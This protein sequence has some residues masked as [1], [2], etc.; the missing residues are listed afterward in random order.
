M[1]LQVIQAHSPLLSTQEK[2]TEEVMI[3]SEE[4]PKADSVTGNTSVLF[5]LTVLWYNNV[6]S[7]YK[8]RGRDKR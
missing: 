3:P 4:A 2:E 7:N 1:N 8:I 5:S 6:K